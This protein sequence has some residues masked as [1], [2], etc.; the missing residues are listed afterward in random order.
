[1]DFA[2]LCSCAARACQLLSVLQLIA[3]A[4]DY[5]CGKYCGIMLADRLS[6]DNA[7]RCVQEQFAPYG[8]IQSIRK[9]ELRRCAFVTYAERS[10]AERAAEALASRLMINGQ[11]CKLFWG[12]PQA[13]RPQPSGAAGSGTGPAPP[14]GMLPPQVAAQMG[15]T[16]P[17]GPLYGAPP[18]APAPANFFNLPPGSG[19]QPMYPSQDPMNMGTS[20]RLA[21]GGGGGDMGGPKRQRMGPGGG[22]PPFFGGPMGG[23]APPMMGFP[24]SWPGARPPPG[25][26]PPGPQPPPVPLQAPPQQA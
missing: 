1:V 25:M 22:P 21:Q 8:F 19:A 6:A 9:L 16:A 10:D 17:A 7:W 4:P 3:D 24:P 23:G 2:V 20:K 11:R 18:G 12:K 13:E 5:I 14:L 26:P 15:S